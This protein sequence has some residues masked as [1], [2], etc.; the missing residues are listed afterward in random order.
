MS[1]LEPIK[2]R[3]TQVAK[4]VGPEEINISSNTPSFTS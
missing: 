2:R 3:A 1:P 4:E